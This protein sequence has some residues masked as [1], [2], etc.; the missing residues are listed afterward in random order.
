MREENDFVGIESVSPRQ[1]SGD[2]APRAAGDR[3]SLN[4]VNATVA[5]QGITA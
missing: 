3:G 4:D 1:A 2:A 5:P